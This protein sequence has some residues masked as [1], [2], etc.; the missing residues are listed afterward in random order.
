MIL[1][2]NHCRCILVD[3]HGTKQPVKNHWGVNRHDDGVGLAYERLA[4][5]N[6]DE[7]RGL[8]ITCN[9]RCMQPP[10]NCA[11]NVTVPSCTDIFSDGHWQILI[12]QLKLPD[13]LDG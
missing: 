9:H 1:G 12:N 8:G 7:C 3:N 5:T 2:N 13:L 10:C 11:A 6:N 4:T